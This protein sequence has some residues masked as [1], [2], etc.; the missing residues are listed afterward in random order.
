[1]S[2]SV[3]VVINVK[4]WNTFM[5]LAIMTFIVSGCSSISENELVL[6]YEQN[7][8]AIQYEQIDEI[9]FEKTPELERAIKLFTDACSEQKQLARLNLWSLFRSDILTWLKAVE[10]V[11]LD[12]HWA[13]HNNLYVVMPRQIA[14]V[15][16]VD[17]AL[18]KEIQTLMARKLSYDL[19][20]SIVSTLS[21]LITL[22]Q[23]R[24]DELNIH[25]E[26]YLERSE[27]WE[28]EPPE[29][30]EYFDWESIPFVS[31]ARYDILSANFNFTHGG[32]ELGII[33][34]MWLMR[35]G[36]H[37]SNIQCFIVLL[38][39][40]SDDLHDTA[41]SAMVSRIVALRDGGFDIYRIYFE[42][43]TDSTRAFDPITKE[44]FERV[45]QLLTEHFD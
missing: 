29:W 33:D 26:D 35:Y 23:H 16:Q 34:A 24:Y 18:Y 17:P 27:I 1:M 32:E 3:R 8:C 42:M 15:R 30:H 36:T 19:C 40:L 13:Y 4:K 10:A 41:I 7:G 25:W 21:L 14:I 38:A 12:H 39:Y 20:E 37:G 5:I 2:I 28:Y 31:G 45:S 11:R 43:L 44:I 9:Y 6:A 22:V